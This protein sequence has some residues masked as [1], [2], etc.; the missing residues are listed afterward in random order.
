MW[1]TLKVAAKLFPVAVAIGFEI[2]KAI[3]EAQNEM[4][5]DTEYED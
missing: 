2:G 5:D 3:A 1:S 4:D